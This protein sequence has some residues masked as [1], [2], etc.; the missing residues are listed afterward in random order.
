MLS[1]RQSQVLALLFQNSRAIHACAALFYLLRTK[2]CAVA[3]PIALQFAAELAE[4]SAR[5]VKRKRR[6]LIYAPRRHI[7][8]IQ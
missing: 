5:P 7:K 3:P 4:E 6:K 2:Y 8:D 1:F